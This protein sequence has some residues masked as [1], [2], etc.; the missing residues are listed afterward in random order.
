MIEKKFLLYYEERAFC[1]S[2]RSELG[3]FRNTE[4]LR[5]GCVLAVSGQNICPGG[6]QVGKGFY[7]S[8][9]FRAVCRASSVKKLAKGKRECMV[10]SED[11]VWY[12]IEINVISD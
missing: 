1:S 2:L 11:V 3:L 5:I 7:C 8:E 6:C 9:I 4:D 12:L 10:S